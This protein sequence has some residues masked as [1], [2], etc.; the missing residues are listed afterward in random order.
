MAPRQIKGIAWA[1]PCLRP[2]ALPEKKPRRGAKAEGLRFENKLA[3][4][5]GPKATQ[6]QWFRFLDDNGPGH[7]QTDLLL[8]GRKR[9]V[10]IECKLTFTLEGMLQIQDLYFPV[11]RTHYPRHEVLGVLACKNLTP[12]APPDLTFGSL[13]NAIEA[14]LS[15]RISVFH[16]FGAAGVDV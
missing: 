12:A 11:L 8:I 10:V 16:W 9:L 2:K 4:A 7:C 1:E 15:G 5:L 3:K 14:A 6:G 13:R